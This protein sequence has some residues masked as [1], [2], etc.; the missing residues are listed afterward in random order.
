MQTIALNDLSRAAAEHPAVMEAIRRVVE[1]GWFIHGPELE[2]FEAQF[3]AYCGVAHGVG[4]GNGTDAIERG[5][6]AIG[7]GPGDEVIAAANAAFYTPT[8]LK[9]IGATP[10]FADIDDTHLLLD[11]QSARAAITPRTKAIV[12][13]H[14]YGRMADMQ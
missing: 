10:V 8:A 4:V 6:R 9:A 14:L 3:A 2:A 13:T 7:V 12:V 11:P 1:R 5:L